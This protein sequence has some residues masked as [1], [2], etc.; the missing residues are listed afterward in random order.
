MSLHRHK[1][2]I[3]QAHTLVFI[4]YKISMS[5]WIVSRLRWKCSQT[6][7]LPSSMKERRFFP[8]LQKTFPSRPITSFDPIKLRQKMAPLVF[9]GNGWFRKSATKVHTY[10]RRLGHWSTRNRCKPH[11]GSFGFL[12]QRDPASQGI[13]NVPPGNLDRVRSLNEKCRTADRSCSMLK[14]YWARISSVSLKSIWV[15]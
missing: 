12:Q 11:L 5:H 6:N 1:L 10:A 2:A 3:L 14:A 8:Q 7:Y 4:L 9:K 15:K 13:E